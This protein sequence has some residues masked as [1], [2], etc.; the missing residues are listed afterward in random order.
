MIMSSAILCQEVCIKPQGWHVAQKNK[1]QNV[2]SK[3]FPL[4]IAISKNQPTREII[5]AQNT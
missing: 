4:L 1:T 5:S 2:M 3:P